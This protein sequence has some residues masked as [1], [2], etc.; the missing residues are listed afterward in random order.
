VVPTVTV[1]LIGLAAVMAV[2]VL[3]ERSGAPAAVLLVAAGL[4]YSVLPGPNLRLDPGVVLLLVIPPLL[5]AAALG[6][7]LVALRGSARAIGGLSVGLVLAT[8]LAVG[9]LVSAVVPG[10]PLAAGVALGAAVAPPDPVAALAIGRRAGLPPRLITLVE[11]E[12]L[13]NDATAL[14]TLGVAVAAAGGTFSLGHAVVQFALAA[15]GGLAVGLAVAFAV[16]LVRKLVDDALVETTLS[17]V[18]PFAAYVAADEIHASGVLAVVVAALWLGHRTSAIQS[19]R[20]RLQGRAVWRLVEFL[21]EGYVFLLIGQQLPAVIRGLDGYSS[22]TIAAAST[23][24]VGVVLVLRPLWIFAAARLPSRLN[25]RLGGDPDTGPELTAREVMALSWAGTRGVITLAAVF[26]LPLGFP[27]RDLILLCAYVLVLVTV[28]GQG[29]TF[30]PVLRRLGIGGT[31]GGEALVRNQARVAA[32]QAGMQCLDQLL[33]RDPQLAAPADTARRAAR[34]RL[35]R[36]QQRVERLSAV[37][38]DE[39]ADAGGY[40]S[41]VVLRRAMLDAEREELLAWRDRGE[42]SDLSLR[43]LERE[44]DFQEE[45]LPET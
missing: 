27:G 28:L 23:V 4:V 43:K 38:D 26:S 7:S 3:A 20:T 33:E 13:L 18:T 1:V 39:L 16:G 11:G 12:G 32:V 35:E 22:G 45:V 9:A 29:L 44:L 19:G 31:D 14:T 21:L 5:Y 2:H 24:T 41:A 15:G 10:L 34:L 40:R 6:S 42:L 37:E 8:A 17:L 25:A 36:Y 30:A